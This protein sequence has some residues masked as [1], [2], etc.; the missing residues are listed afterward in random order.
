MSQIPDVEKELGSSKHSHRF[1]LRRGKQ[2][3]SS[4]ASGKGHTHSVEGAPTSGADDGMSH[5]HSVELNGVMIESGPPVWP[6]EAGF[7]NHEVVKGFMPDLIDPDHEYVFKTDP[8]GIPDFWYQDRM[9]NYWRYTNAP[10]DHA[11]FDPKWGLPL[12]DR[13][14]P[15]P[16]TAPQYFADNGRKRNM[17]VPMEIQSEV[18]PGYDPLDAR[19]LWYETFVGTDGVRRFVYLDSD[20]R[21]NLDLWVQYQLRLTDA[22]I[23]RFRQFAA[24]L[25]SNPH[26]KDKVVGAILM[27]C[28]QGL[29]DMEALADALVEDLEFID[30]SVKL[31]GRKFVCDPKFYD[32]LTSLVSGRE[33]SAPLF[34]IDTGMGRLSVGYHHMYAVFK[35]LKMS[36][37]YLLYWRASQMFSRIMTRLALTTQPDAEEIE[38]LAMSEL[39][40]MFGTR[41]NIKHMVDFKVRQQLTENYGGG[42]LKALPRQSADDWGVLTV[43]SDLVERRVDEKSFSEWLHAEPM[44]D[45]TPEEEA[46]IEEQIAQLEEDRGGNEPDQT[47]TDGQPENPGE[48]DKQDTAGQTGPGEVAGDVNATPEGGA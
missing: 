4:A 34:Y 47:E 13:E 37:E 46:M 15:M 10:E 5:T 27:L 28:D 20:V 32:F 7:D 22:G 17:A 43:W 44:H 26:P 3:L 48:T 18:N 2:V 30:E 6:I 14:Q 23:T 31:L 39:Q 42:V 21:E 8:Y 19:N 1:T 25:F 36:P 12:M 45:L 41:D 35:F 38:G 40:R 24:N 9:G 11:D 16:H 33:P 29:Y